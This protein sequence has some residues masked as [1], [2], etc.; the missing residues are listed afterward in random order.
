VIALE[1]IWNIPALKTTTK[2]LLGLGSEDGVW[3]ELAYG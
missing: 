2:F 3:M 1:N